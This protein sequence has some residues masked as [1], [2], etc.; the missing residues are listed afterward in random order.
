MTPEPTSIFTAL[1]S[2]DA[3]HLGAEFSEIYWAVEPLEDF[4]NIY[5]VSEGGSEE[6]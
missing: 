4:C 2:I 1:A 6:G 3:H 5:N